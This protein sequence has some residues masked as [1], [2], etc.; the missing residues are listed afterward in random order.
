MNIVGPV[1]ESFGQLIGL[2]CVAYSVWK[3]FACFLSTTAFFVVRR[4]LDLSYNEI[5]S[6]PASMFGISSLR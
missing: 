2:Q 1:P 4:V 5:K 3:A 6:L